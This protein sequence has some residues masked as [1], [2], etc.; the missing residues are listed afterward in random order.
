LNT[1]RWSRHSRRIEPITRSTYARCQGER[2][3]RQHFFDVHVSHLFSEVLAKDAVAVAQQIARDLVK[4]EG[5]S[6]LLTNPLSGWMA[7]HVE[8]KN[9]PTIMRQDQKHVEV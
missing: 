7:T 4:G 9:P 3:G 2:G 1:I 8:V 6:Q 5:F